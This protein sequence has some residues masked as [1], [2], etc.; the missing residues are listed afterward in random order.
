LDG[1]KKGCL[2]G[3]VRGGKGRSIRFKREGERDGRMEGLGATKLDGRKSSIGS[4][5]ISIKMHAAFRRT[6]KYISR[7]SY[8]Y[9]HHLDS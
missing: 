2:Q 3:E 6:Q 5:I 7:Y 9:Y 1:D 8:G 4:R